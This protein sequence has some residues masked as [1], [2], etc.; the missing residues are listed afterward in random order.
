[1]PDDWVKRE[2]R[3]FALPS[4]VLSAL[5]PYANIVTILLHTVFSIY[6]Y[7]VLVYIYIYI[8]IY[9]ISVLH[10]KFPDGQVSG[11]KLTFHQVTLDCSSHLLHLQH[12]G[13]HQTSTRT[14]MS[15]V[16]KSKAKKAM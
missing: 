7:C 9:C 1:M 11:A 5:L 8:Y 3:N 13:D 14:G 10:S 4:M 15:L 16:K 12:L 6:I 2:T